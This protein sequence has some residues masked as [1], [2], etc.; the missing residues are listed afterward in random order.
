[1]GTIFEVVGSNPAIAYSE[2][3]M[4]ATLSQIY[5]ENFVDFDFVFV[6]LSNCWIIFFKYG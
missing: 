3:K 6:I 2:E 4:F 5:P 1:M